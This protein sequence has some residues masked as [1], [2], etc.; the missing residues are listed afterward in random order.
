VL[1][2]S[3]IGVDVTHI[4]YRGTG[5]AMQD[6]IAG[7]IDYICDVIQT[8]FSQATQMVPSLD[9]G[10]HFIAN[11]ANPFPNGFNLPTGNSLGASTFLGLGVGEGVFIDYRSPYMQQWNLNVQRELPGRIVFEAAYIGSKGTRLLAGESGVPLSQLPESFLSLGTQLQDQVPNPF[12]GI[13]TNPSSPLRFQTVSRG[14]LLRPYPQYNGVNAFRVP[15]GYSIYH[16]A[17]LKADRRFSSGLSFLT[18][19]TW[20]RLIDDVSTTVGFLGQASTRQNAYDREAERAIGSQDIRHRFVTSFVYELPFG[21]GKQFG[22]HWNS[23]ASWLLGGWQINGIVEFQS[24]LPLIIT[25][26]QNNVGLFNPTQRPTWNGNDANLGGSTD[27]KLRTWF[28]TSAFS[29]TPAFTWGNT[30]RVMPDLRADGT[31]N[32]NLSLFKNN[33]FKGGK[34]NTQFRAE[35]FNAF[36]RVQFSAPATRVDSSNFGVVSGQANSPRQVQLSL[37]LIF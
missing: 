34:F 17:T 12:F 8:G 37:K 22:E 14:R 25:Q 35:F 15:Y 2:N 32:F 27:D 24:G 20:N 33:S 5:P 36:N 28:D 23:A 9:N 11:L 3:A 13:I 7:R 30:P 31:K 4:P 6:I 26:G 19:Y 1:L 16:G 21:R 29:I 10:Q 18:A